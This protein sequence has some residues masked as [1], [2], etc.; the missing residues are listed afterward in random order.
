MAKDPKKGTGKHPGKNMVDDFT[1]MKTRVTLLELSL[2]PLM[3]LV[4]LL[5]KLRRYL[6]RLREK[7]KS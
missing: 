2:R 1:L 7:Y 5:Q 4:R 3:M 6:N